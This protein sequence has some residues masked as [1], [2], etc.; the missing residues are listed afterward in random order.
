MD[1]KGYGK[2]IGFAFSAHDIYLP[3]MHFHYLKTDR[4]PQ[5]CAFRFGCIKGPKCL[6]Y[7]TFRYPN[8]CIRDGKYEG[9]RIFFE[10]Y[11][12]R[13]GLITQSLVSVVKK[14]VH[15]HL[16]LRKVRFD[17]IFF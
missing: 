11:R 8:T 12:Y 3:S 7:V 5:T 9:L 17:R 16:E 2:N 4:K 15:K 6:I 13:P 10:L 1:P 14:V